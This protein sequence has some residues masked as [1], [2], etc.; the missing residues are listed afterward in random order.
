M[1]VDGEDYIL[2]SGKKL[3][4][5]CGFV[6][7]NASFDVSHGYDGH[8]LCQEY[9]FGKNIEELT[10]EEKNELASFMITRWEIFRDMSEP[11]FI[12]RYE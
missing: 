2:H 4:A 7:I 12:K 11:E 10:F 6:G 5:H 3:E 1:I 8:W 9:C